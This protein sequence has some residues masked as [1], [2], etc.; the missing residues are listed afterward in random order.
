[1]SGSTSS[2]IWTKKKLEEK[3]FRA[4]IVDFFGDSNFF[5]NPLGSATITIV[6]ARTTSMKTTTTTTITLIC[7]DTFEI[8]LV[9]Y[10]SLRG[11]IT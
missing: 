3:S 1:M 11:G 4:K 6:K 9:C 5:P 8:N 7:F 2:Y 10:E